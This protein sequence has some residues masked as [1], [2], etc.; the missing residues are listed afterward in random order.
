MSG[1]IPRMSLMSFLVHPSSATICSFVRVVSWGCDQVLEGRKRTV[2]E[3]NSSLRLSAPK[4]F[5]W[6]DCEMRAATHCPAISCPRMWVSRR[7]SG[8][9]RILE[10]MVKNWTNANENEPL[11]SGRQRAYFPGRVS[12]HR[13][14]ERVSVQVIEE[15]G[16]V[17]RGSWTNARKES[18]R[19][20]IMLLLPAVESLPSSK[21][22]PHVPAVGQVCGKH[23]WVST[24]TAKRDGEM[25]TTHDDVRVAEDGRYVKGSASYASGS[26]K[27]F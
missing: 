26:T 9:P 25:R 12:T 3:Q 7:M 21:D 11:T 2:Q 1:L 14:L 5:A 10:P 18:Q 19:A 16:R 4:R 13:S 8:W 27:E 17:D 23:R 20:R 15:V 6:E 24:R 22:V